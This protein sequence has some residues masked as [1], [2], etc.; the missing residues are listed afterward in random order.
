M[1]GMRFVAPPSATPKQAAR[2]AVGWAL[3]RGYRPEGLHAYTNADAGI[4]FWRIRAKHPVTSHKVI[5]PMHLAPLGYVLSEPAYPAGKPLYRLHRLYAQPGEPVV[6]VEGEKCADAMARL[7][8]LATTSGGADSA[9]TADW[10]PLAGREVRVWPDNDS[11]GQRYGVAVARTL[12][13]LGCDVCVI[14]VNALA[15]PHGGDVVDWLDQHPRAV[16]TDVLQLA[17]THC[18]SGRGPA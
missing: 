5:R 10:S 17:R 11:P 7:G 1:T 12:Q 4:E 13:R 15:L 18:T 14:D 3:A 9:S 2:L 16:A 6:V 8:L